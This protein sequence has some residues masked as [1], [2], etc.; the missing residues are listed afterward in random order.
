MSVYAVSDLHGQFDAFA[1]GL[2]K[3]DLRESDMLYVIGDAVDR[4]PDSIGIL[5]YIKDHPNM[6]LLIGNHEFMM[7]NSVDPGGEDICNGEDTDLWLY[8]NGGL[9]TYEQY[10]RFPPEERR[11]LLSW[12]RQRS[13]IRTLEVNGEPFCLTHSYF[14]EDLADKTFEELSYEE[15]SDIVWRSV[16]RM[17]PDTHGED[18]YGDYDCTFITGHVPVIL[19]MREFAGQYDY[20]DL[21]IFEK[22]NFI[23]IDGGC[24]IGYREGVHNG[25]LFFRLDD[26]KVFPVPLRHP[27]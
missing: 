25:A 22:G 21:R 27:A 5:K 14:R 24:S 9:A 4:G 13:V 18:I 16:Y 8:N 1:E 12:L 17:E 23:D 2:D 7:L 20:N 11:S 6:D 15:V 19:V 26:K 10:R 3:I